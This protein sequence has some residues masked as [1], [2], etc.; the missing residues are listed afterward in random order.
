MDE[1]IQIEAS[2]LNQKTYNWKTQKHQKEK[3]M[4]IRGE[5]K[6]TYIYIY[7]SNIVM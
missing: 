5:L 4:N 2:K 3:G 7:I 6:A 1:A